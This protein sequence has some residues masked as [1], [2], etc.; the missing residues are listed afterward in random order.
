[1]TTVEETIKKFKKIFDETIENGPD[2]K[3]SLK[4][5]NFFKMQISHKVDKIRKWGDALLADIEILDTPNGNLLK[6]LMKTDEIVFRPKSYF[7][8][9]IKN[10][11]TKLFHNNTHW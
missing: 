6:E 3:G 10:L 8:Y 5:M 2:Y 4:K 9:G 7:R 1:M 11:I